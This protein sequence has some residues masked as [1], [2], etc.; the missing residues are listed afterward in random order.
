MTTEKELKDEIEY[1]E[2]KLM[3]LG[4]T[5]HA[6]SVLWNEIAKRND[7]LKS[8]LKGEPNGT[9]KKL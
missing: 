5:G 3:L 1:N 6:Y 8:K 7:E 4:M 9:A 2:N